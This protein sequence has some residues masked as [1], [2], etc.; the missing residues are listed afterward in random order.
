M[1]EATQ[2]ALLKSLEEPPAATVFILV[3]SNPH[4]LLPTIRSRCQAVSLP[5]PDQQ[6]ALAWLREQQVPEPERV[7]ALAGGAPL[8]AA[9]LAERAPFIAE[10]TSRL[11]DTRLD[12]LAL[13]ASC[14]HAAAPEVVVALQR[15]C[16]DLLSVS[17]A[18]RPRYHPESLAALREAS[19]RCRP[20]KLA[21]FLRTLAE[22]ARLSQHPLNAQLFFEDLLVRYSG[23]FAAKAG[24]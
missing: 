24:R 8:A 7:L 18:E 20:E 19:R 10:F 12:P 11:A 6:A 3:T 4:R 23:L 5:R 17:L 9:D 22:A 21:G 16:Y 1:N 14:R 2:N 13:A 15:W